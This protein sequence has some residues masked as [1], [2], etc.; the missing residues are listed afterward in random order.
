M[1]LILIGCKLTD[2]IKYFFL[3]VWFSLVWFDYYY[4]V[5]PEAALRRFCMC[6]ADGSFVAKLKF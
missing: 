6:G 3:L 5:F 2:H 4:Y 1:I